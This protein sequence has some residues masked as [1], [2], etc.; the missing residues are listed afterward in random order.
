M[1][2]MWISPFG[3]GWSI[4]AKLRDSGNKVV[5]FCPDPKNKNGSGYLPRVSEAEWMDYAKRSD[6]VVVDNNFESRRTRRSFA[7]SR[8]VEDL[9][10][11]RRLPNVQYIGP[12]P[13]SELIENDPRYQAKIAK[14]LGLPLADIIS[15]SGIAVTVSYSLGQG[16]AWLIFR[17]RNLLGDE[18]GPE[19]GNLGD[20]CV[21]LNI[22]SRIFAET[23]GKATELFQ[24]IKYNSFV[25]YEVQVNRE[26]LSLVN[27]RTSFLYPAI[28]CQFAG[29]P[30]LGLA[31]TLFRFEDFSQVLT[32]SHLGFF[33]ANVEATGRVT[34]PFVG[35]VA[36]V[37]SQLD[38][39]QLSVYSI[40]QPMARPGLGFRDNIGI[41]VPS[42]MSLLQE[43]GW[44]D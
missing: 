37:D 26:L 22:N 23:A 21:P 25:N 13:T 1:R 24:K 4:A 20:V 38:A 5:Y 33:P 6:L 9:G 29:L 34:G 19:V 12:V 40:L 43:W 18:N 15:V 30:S 28:F 17:H 11:I 3:D 27:I 16:L 36:G 42:Q 39:L 2:I 8:Y 35:A 44:L 41:G 14:R 31:V 32:D 10:A 7:P